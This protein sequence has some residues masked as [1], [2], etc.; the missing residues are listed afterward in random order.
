M[1]YAPK[2]ILTFSTTPR[3]TKTK[4]DTMDAA[5]SARGGTPC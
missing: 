4:N 3:P 5:P 1:V 2:T